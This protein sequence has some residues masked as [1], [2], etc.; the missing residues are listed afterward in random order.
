M[1]VLCHGQKLHFKVFKYFHLPELAKQSC[2]DPT[3]HPLHKWAGISFRRKDFVRGVNGLRILS[4]GR[5]LLLTFVLFA[6][7]SRMFLC[8]FVHQITE[9]FLL[10]L[11]GHTSTDVVSYF[12][13]KQNFPT[14]T[15]FQKR[16]SGLCV[17]VGVV[18]VCVCVWGEGQG[19]V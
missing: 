1:T 5:H 3:P 18:C 10:D 15:G 2:K 11:I 17:W 12:I 19:Q 7:I 13:R 4:G 9:I 6:F 16:N 8:L 14:D